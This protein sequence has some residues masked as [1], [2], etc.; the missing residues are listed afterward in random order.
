MYLDRN[1]NCIDDL[2]TF[3]TLAVVDLPRITH[4]T[5]PHLLRIGQNVSLRCTTSGL[6]LLNV[7]WYKDG[8]RVATN[9]GN[10]TSEAVFRLYNITVQDWGEYVCVTKN[11]V[12]EDRRTV[13]LRSKLYLLVFK[14][15]SGSSLSIII[16]Q[17]T[18]LSLVEDPKV[19]VNLIKKL[20]KIN[21]TLRFLFVVQLRENLLG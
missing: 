14:Y 15:I 17:I 13:Y 7:T 16:L 10:G 9:H 5:T 11:A 4:I 19:F 12:G 2:C 21:L 8:V 3:C 1:L 18:H 6:S 20:V